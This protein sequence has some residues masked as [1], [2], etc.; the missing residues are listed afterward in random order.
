MKHVNLDD[1]D[2]KVYQKSKI[3]INNEKNLLQLSNLYK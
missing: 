1:I 3:N 2:I